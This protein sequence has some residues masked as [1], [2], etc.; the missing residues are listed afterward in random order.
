MQPQVAGVGRDADRQDV[1]AGQLDGLLGGVRDLDRLG[2]PLALGALGLDGERVRARLQVHGPGHGDRAH[3]GRLNGP[4]ASLPLVGSA[5]E[6]QPQRGHRVLA[7]AAGGRLDLQARPFQVRAGTSRGGDLDLGR[8]HLDDFDALGGLAPGLIGDLEG[9]CQAAGRQQELD[10]VGAVERLAEL[11]GG[12]EGGHLVGAVVDVPAHEL[13]A[14]GAGGV[15][16]LGCPGDPVVAGEE[17]RQ[18]RL[19]AVGVPDPQGLVVGGRE[20]VAAVG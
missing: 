4:D 20:Q 5:I 12:V 3:L 8:E 15:V 10:H 6:Q 7:D 16:A 1:E 2:Q 13:L 17:E 11:R 14:A 9:A 18:Q 19:V